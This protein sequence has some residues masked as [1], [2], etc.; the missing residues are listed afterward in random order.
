M[1]PCWPVQQS[2]G[3]YGCGGGLTNQWL[4]YFGKYLG[5]SIG[6]QSSERHY[7]PKRSVQL[8]EFGELI[9][10]GCTASHGIHGFVCVIVYPFDF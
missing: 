5:H 9:A 8:V 6:D 10:F 3:C 7:R 1:L 2:H 4:K